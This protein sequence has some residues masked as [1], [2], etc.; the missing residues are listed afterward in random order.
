MTAHP[1]DDAAPMIR[2]PLHP[3][4]R[5]GGRKGHAVGLIKVDDPTRDIPRFRGKCP[6][7]SR[8]G[9][10]NGCPCPRCRIDAELEAHQWAA[11]GAGRVCAR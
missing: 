10:L 2:L 4:K 3:R 1:F 7:R 5:I 9:T 6:P 8:V 11:M